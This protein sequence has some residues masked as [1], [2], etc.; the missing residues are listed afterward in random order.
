MQWYKGRTV[1]FTV[2]VMQGGAPID[3]TSGSAQLTVVDASAT[4]VKTYATGGSGIV[5]TTPA[6]GLM[7][8]SPETGGSGT[9]DF[10]VDVTYYA[11]LRVTLADSSVYP[12]FL[13]RI[14]LTD[15]R[16]K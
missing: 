2:Q 3:I 9:N 4:T 12:C 13:A 1:P 10:A 15:R 11:D 8:I 6:S 14:T 7:T 16:D 5:F